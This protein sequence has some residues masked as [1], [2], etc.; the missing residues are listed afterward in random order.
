VIAEA[1]GAWLALYKA[2]T[3]PNSAAMLWP[4]WKESSNKLTRILLANTNL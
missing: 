2:D 1:V 3:H 4:T